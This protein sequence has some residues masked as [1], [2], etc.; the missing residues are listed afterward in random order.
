MNF[1]VFIFYLDS[2]PKYFGQIW[3]DST[4]FQGEFSRGLRPPAWNLFS[5]PSAPETIYF[6]AYGII[7]KRRPVY[8]G[9]GGLKNP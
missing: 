1:A 6:L 2:E 5:S 3:R 8:L 4:E 7:Q 9:E